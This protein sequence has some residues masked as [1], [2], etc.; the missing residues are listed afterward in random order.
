MSLL[1]TLDSE[2]SHKDQISENNKTVTTK[3]FEDSVFTDTEID[4][5]TKLGLLREIHIRNLFFDHLNIKS[6][7]NKREYLEPLIRNSRLYVI[8][9]KTEINIKE[10]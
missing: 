8:F 7:R 6:L 2:N 4:G 10:L 5:F 3:V 9:V 1:N